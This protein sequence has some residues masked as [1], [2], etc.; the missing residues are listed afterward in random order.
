MGS[1]CSAP[2][3]ITVAVLTISRDRLLLDAV[4]PQFLNKTNAAGNQYQNDNND[5]SRRIFLTEVASQTLVTKDTKANP[6][7][8]TVKGVNDRLVNFL[9]N[10]VFLTLC[11]DIF[12]IEVTIF[13]DLLFCPGPERNSC[14]MPEF[15]AQEKAEA[16]TK[17]SFTVFIGFSFMYD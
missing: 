17:I 4:A 3:R 9:E 8:M 5:G 13:F 7:R 2:S 10:R 12:T 15:L 6:N 14:K 1:S 11:D 16:T